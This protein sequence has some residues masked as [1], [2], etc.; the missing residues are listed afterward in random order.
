MSERPT[1]LKPLITA[2]QRNCGKAMFSQAFVSHSV[3]RAGWVFTTWGGY[4]RVVGTHPLLG[5]LLTPPPH[6]Y[7]ELGYGWRYASYWNAFLFTKLIYRTSHYSSCLESWERTPPKRKAISGKQLTCRTQR[8][9]TEL[10]SLVVCCVTP[11][12]IFIFNKIP[13]E[14]FCSGHAFL[15]EIRRIIIV[16]FCGKIK[17]EY[18]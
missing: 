12:S 7:T 15:Q 6:R 11:K 18:I 16:A 1:C 3:H 8:K 4:A 9:I 13:A 5:W 10:P 2:H 17:K 14:I